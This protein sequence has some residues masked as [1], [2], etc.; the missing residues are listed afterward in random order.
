MCF[1]FGLSIESKEGDEC[2]MKCKKCKKEIRQMAWTVDEY[3]NRVLTEVVPEMGDFPPQLFSII[4]DK[5]KPKLDFD[6]CFCK[7]KKVGK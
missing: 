3:G 7:Q 4:V 5:G 1:L 6:I 2:E